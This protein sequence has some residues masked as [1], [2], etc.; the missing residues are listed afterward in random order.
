MKK[1]KVNISFYYTTNDLFFPSK[2]DGHNAVDDLKIH[3]LNVNIWVMTENLMNII[4]CGPIFDR[5]TI[6]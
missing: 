3:L 5:L 1:I 2:H 4:L 6:G